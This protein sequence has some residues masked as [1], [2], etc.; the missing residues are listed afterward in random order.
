MKQ[1]EQLK[2]GELKEILLTKQEFLEVREQLMKREDFKHFIGTAYPGG[3]VKYVW[4]PT[5]RT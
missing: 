5:A 3:S 1:F 2:A 4:S